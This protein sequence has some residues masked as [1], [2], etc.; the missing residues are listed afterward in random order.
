MILVS[1]NLLKLNDKY[2]ELSTLYTSKDVQQ[3]FKLP[4]ALSSFNTSHVSSLM[5]IPMAHA[6]S[7]FNHNSEKYFDGFVVLSNL[8]Y[9]IFLTF[10]QF[11][12]CIG[13]SRHIESVCFL[14]PCLVR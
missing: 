9:K 3:F 6:D 7:T 10:P 4:L 12:N 5:R 1:S 8:Y 14:R 13:D 2:P 11:D